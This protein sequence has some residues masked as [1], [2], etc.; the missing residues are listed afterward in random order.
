MG[1]M[2]TKQKIASEALDLFSLRGYGA[3]SVRDIAKK[4]G[5]KESSLYNH[6]KSKQDVFDSIVEECTRIAEGFFKDMNITDTLDAEQNEELEHLS[7]EDFLS[8]SIGIF[9]FYLQEEN[10]VKFRRLLTIEQFNNPK[11]GELFRK[12]FIDN[13]LNYQ[14]K[15][16]SMLIENGIFI[17]VDPYVLAMQF[18]APVFLMFYKFD[19]V[20]DE[21]SDILISHVIQF[22]EIY[23]KK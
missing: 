15:V 6:F 5:I 19:E 1:E 14:T 4:V 13:A 20:T 21:A 17:E 16:F 2:T 18:Y 10:L 8:M 22:K 3:V 23:T 7:D 12:V 11:I 9:Q